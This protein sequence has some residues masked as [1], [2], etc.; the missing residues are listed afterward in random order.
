[1]EFTNGDLMMQVD[2]DKK[3]EQFKKVVA[4]ASAVVNHDC[5]LHIDGC[6]RFG[7]HQDVDKF[8]EMVGPFFE[9][10]GNGVDLR[11][12]K[13]EFIFQ[14]RDHIEVVI[15]DNGGRM[16]MMLQHSLYL[17]GQDRTIDFMRADAIARYEEHAQDIQSRIDRD[18][19]NLNDILTQIQNI[20]Q[21]S[22]KEIMEWLN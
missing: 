10:L 11:K 8:I 15:V 4:A 5:S 14:E 1:M 9:K 22:D 13:I 18:Q 6:M 17:A 19:R 3:N 7:F 2:R 21:A 20:K 16:T 12:C